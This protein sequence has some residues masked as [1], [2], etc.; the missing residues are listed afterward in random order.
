MDPEARRRPVFG[1]AI[2][3]VVAVAIGVP[4]L[5]FVHETVPN[6][7]DAKRDVPEVGLSPAVLARSSNLPEAVGA[8]PAI[9]YHDVSGRGGVFT[10]SPQRFAEHM[11]ALD[12]A[13]FE[14]IGLDEVEALISG[15]DP[16]LPR[17]PILLTFDDGTASTWQRADPVLE[18]HGFR[19]TAFI[20]TSAI[21]ERGPSYYL[22]WEQL[23]LLSETGRWAFGAHTHEGHR[24]V[25]IGRGA[26]GPWLTNLERTPMGDETLD[27]WRRQV[28][29]DFDRNK[30]ELARRTGTHPQALAYPFSSDRQQFNDDR[31][32]LELG[33]IVS[34]EF[35]M[36][37]TGGDAR[38]A[39]TA[40]APRWNLPRLTVRSNLTAE[41]LLGAI[42][43]MLPD[44]FPERL[45]ALRWHAEG[46][47]C[48]GTA[49]GVSI[50]ADRYATCAPATNASA[51]TDYHARLRIA[52]IDRHATA[53]VGVRRG[54]Y[55]R[56]EV[57]LGESGAVVRQFIDGRW[58]DVTRIDGPPVAP[59]TDVDVTLIGNQ[60]TVG[61]G[62]RPPV[63]V[64]LDARLR[65]GGLLLGVAT[66]R[67]ATVTVDQ[68][69]L[70]EV[71]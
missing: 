52:G 36:A 60:L 1:L 70:E 24:T 16:A 11:A 50:S 55:G 13:G 69:R 38:Q 19:A 23:G 68:D 63:E 26:T 14:P 54:D 65:S 62:G 18:R 8:I 51:W 28:I 67:P 49:S 53:L 22:S 25:E 12:A 61:V 31:I 44:R 32:P 4:L 37:F 30:T 56:A 47:T 45:G 40:G 5:A 46:G 17:R 35:P 10:V 9:N 33:R 48:T 3:V 57:A 15:R 58:T 20:V 34:H 43:E 42:G 66:R 59:V 41:G 7:I 29:E 2:S 39:I 6:G 21:V 64:S 27:H 71:R